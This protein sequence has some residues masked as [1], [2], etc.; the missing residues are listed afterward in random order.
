MNTVTQ[1]HLE[2]LVT[3][4]G[5]QALEDTAISYRNLIRRSE[6][7]PPDEI[8]WFRHIMAT[9]YGSP[10]EHASL[11]NSSRYNIGILPF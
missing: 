5:W 7:S 6:I 4:I 10:C 9:L 2:G 8:P 3:G 1:A 11:V